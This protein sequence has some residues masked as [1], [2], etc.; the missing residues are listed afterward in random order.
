MKERME[1]KIRKMFRVFVILLIGVGLGYS[2]RMFQE[3]QW[4]NQEVV[5]M[6]Q[7]LNENNQ[8]LEEHERYLRAYRALI[9]KIQKEGRCK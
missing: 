7:I 1:K 6:R 8:A 9:I 2:W 3:K 4:L 5:E